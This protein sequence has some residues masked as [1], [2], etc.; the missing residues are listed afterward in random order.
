MILG[1][2]NDSQTPSGYKVAPMSYAKLKDVAE[3]LR[4]L[5]PTVTGSAGFRIDA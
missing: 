3:Q 2:E 1:N 5:L 4:T